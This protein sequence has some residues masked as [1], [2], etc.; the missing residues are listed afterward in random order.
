LKRFRNDLLFFKFFSKKGG[1]KRGR[2]GG[3][4]EMRTKVWQELSR[5]F[6][7]RNDECGRNHSSKVRGEDR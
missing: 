3:G 7:S 5:R 6:L 1:K 2:E 4:E